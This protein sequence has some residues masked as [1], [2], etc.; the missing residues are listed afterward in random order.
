[1]CFIRTEVGTRKG[2]G[3]DEEKNSFPHQD[4]DWCAAEA[5][6]KPGPRGI[7]ADTSQCLDTGSISP[8]PALNNSTG[9]SDALHLLCLSLCLCCSTCDVFHILHR[10]SAAVITELQRVWSQA[11]R[12]VTL[13]TDPDDRERE[14][15]ALGLLGWKII[16][17]TDQRRM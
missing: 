7:D 14:S 12:Q 11:V 16:V 15:A 6:L 4:V 10:W 8:A 3:A 1:M 2:G 5:D 9:H 17:M 13:H